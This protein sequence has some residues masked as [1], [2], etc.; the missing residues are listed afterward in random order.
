[1]SIREIDKA[2]VKS[3]ASGS[4][5]SDI[6][7]AIRELIE[8]SIDACARNIEIR[9]ARFGI[10]AIE[11][12]DDGTGIQEENFKNL[13]LR[14]H[15]SKISDFKALQESLDTFGFRGEA[16]SCL[17]N[18]AHVIINTKTKSSPTGTKLT[19]KSDGSLGKK[20]HMARNEGTTVIIKE[21]FHSL[22]VRRKELITSAKRQYDKVVKLLYEHVIARPHIKFTLCK[23]SSTKKDKDFTHGGTSL[24]GVIIT[25]F[26]VKVMESLMPIK[27]AGAIELT[28]QTSDNSEPSTSQD[29]SEATA[30][31]IVMDN[32]VNASIA[33]FEVV[34][35]PK[36]DLFFTRSRRSKFKCLKPEY[37]IYGYI[38]KVNEGRNSHDCQFIYVNKRPCD[39]PKISKMINEIY[40]NYTPNQYPFYCLFI[41]VQTW[42]SDFNVPRKRAVILQ[43]ENKLIDIV[44][45]C[46][47]AMFSPHAPAKQ[48]S[49]PNAHIPFA[50]QNGPLTEKQNNLSTT[51]ESQDNELQQSDKQPTGAKRDLRSDS[52]AEGDHITKKQLTD[53]TGT[54]LLR[55][56]E[57]R[58]EEQLDVGAMALAISDPDDFG[59]ILRRER[60]QRAT[61]IDAKKYTFAIHPKFNTVAEQEL[62]FNLNK[63]SFKSMQVIGQF[64]KG[65]IIARLNKHIFIIDQHATDER[66]NYEEQLEKSPFMS[67]PMVHPKPLYL[68]SIQESAIIDNLEDFQ[69]KGFQFAIDESKNPGLRV[70][71]TSTSICK[72]NGADEHLTKEDLE[73]LID[74]ALNAPNQLKTYTLKKVKRV[75]ASRA[76]RKSVM[77]GDKLTWSQ[78]DNI[79]EKMSTLENPW[80]CAHDRPTIRHL[81]DTDWMID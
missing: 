76:C 71:L 40:R 33:Q 65:F 50:S 67:Q 15:T 54:A 25:I 36:R 39:I 78:M 31:S 43:D 16:L 57:D 4:K 60:V 28:T 6:E 14:Y 47:E 19:F 20:E 58:Q 32:Q 73:E 42:A 29:G 80:V 1:M 22:P 5:I 61:I 35:P 52:D 38:S 81:M 79:V 55:G 53:D 11:V 68:N 8:N 49:C 37:T 21:L 69:K 66:A 30:D 75:A 12:Q 26:G 44:R 63:S 64:N 3:I 17:C 74:V 48:K 24:T 59:A 62:K 45:D 9:L 27:Q 18:L 77:I 10:D 41:Q 13:G 56:Q 70:L 46:L 51:T 2:S 72:G 7:D 23:K 34:T